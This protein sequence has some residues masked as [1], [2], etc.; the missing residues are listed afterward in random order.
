MLVCTVNMLL[1]SVTP[2]HVNKIHFV[3]VLS[4]DTDVFVLMESSA[5][6]VKVVIC[7][8]FHYFIEFET[9]LIKFYKFHIIK[10]KTNSQEVNKDFFYRILYTLN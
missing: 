5:D 9:F 1:I 10:L 7:F 8:E 3:K 4:V 6:I 2:T